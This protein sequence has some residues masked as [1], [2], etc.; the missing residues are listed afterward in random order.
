MKKYIIFLYIF[1]Y[2]KNQLYSQSIFLNKKWKIV[3]K[4]QIIPVDTTIKIDK[5]FKENL[6]TEYIYDENLLQFINSDNLKTFYIYKPNIE[7]NEEKRKLPPF[8][9]FIGINLSR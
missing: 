3:D 9:K 8:F 5:Y 4:S 6:T 1:F 7:I 2:S